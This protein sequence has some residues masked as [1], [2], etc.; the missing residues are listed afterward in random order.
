MYRTD[1][2][3]D[4]VDIAIIG[5]IKQSNFQS[6]LTKAATHQLVNNTSLYQLRQKRMLAK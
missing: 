2:I 1:F 4:Q 6:S 5:A 3:V